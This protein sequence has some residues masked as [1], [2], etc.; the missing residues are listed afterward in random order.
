MSTEA[1]SIAKL[2]PL[3]TKLA[4]IFAE[5]A[6]NA[7][8]KTKEKLEIKFER[9]FASFIQ[10]HIDR[11]STVKTIISSSTPIPLLSFYVNLYV[12]NP[13]KAHRDEDFL[14]E[15]SKVKR[16][17]FT[18]IAGSGKSMLMRYLYLKFLETQSERL[19]VF[20]ELRELNEDPST[21]I[22]EQIRSKIADYI[23]GFS[24]H[25]LKFALESGRVIL[26]L[27]GFDEINH[28]VRAERERQINELAARYKN[29]WIFVSSRPAE[30]F[31]SWEK[32]SVYS[33]QPFTRK[34]V[35]LLISKIAYDE[36]IKG[37]FR[38]KLAE[39]LY[40]THA[41]F[42]KNPLLTIM[43]L[44]TLEQFAEVPAKIHLFY[45]Y[46]FEALFGRHDA[47]KGGGFQ[48]KRH[49]SLALDD[50]KRLFSYFCAITY[51]KKLTIF[52]SSRLLEFIHESITASQIVTDKIEFQKDLVE[53]TCM[54][55]MDG[56]DYT[57]SHRSFQEY[58]TAYFLSRVKVDEFER[59]L[60]TLVQRGSFDG[61]LKM[62]SEMNNE[63][64]EE[65]W[66][67]PTLELMCNATQSIDAKNNCLGYAQV[68]IGRNLMLNLG[69]MRIGSR[70]GYTY[71]HAFD[72]MLEPQGP[73]S[74]HAATEGES[75]FFNARIALYSIYGVFD[76][77]HSQLKSRRPLD[78][79]IRRKMLNK[80][81]LAGDH[82][83]DEL[84]KEG[85]PDSDGEQGGRL[86][87]IRLQ[88]DDNSWLCDTYFGHFLQIESEL[89]PKLRDEVAR[90]VKLRRQGTLRI[91]A[92]EE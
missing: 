65:C 48:R 5:T 86:T 85:G 32:F 4:A 39:G 24:E 10:E 50:F 9:G 38:K 49:T 83:L 28:D 7:A 91:F 43:M 89:L 3:I 80:E 58:F 64:F 35:E 23:E 56:L 71:E 25:Q 16:V 75:P 87:V 15:I 13:V 77:I 54:L 17:L 12:A 34:Q 27:D 1:L 76:R 73:Q 30:T 36:E 74:S 79:Q 57:F 42:L 51:L 2:A 53:C 72:I 62:L 69:A 21:T 45:E 6:K 66:A 67:A 37:L 20:I 44:I 22:R 60:P 90:R 29:L 88:E 84:F 46:A 8:T 81:L 52:S 40:E 41:E 78:E 47:T 68:I 14:R 31:A 26:F 18:A 11:F 92:V 70:K 59:A 55:V 19:P 33:V 82:R 63:K 61:V